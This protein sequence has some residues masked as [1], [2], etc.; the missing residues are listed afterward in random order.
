VKTFFRFWYDFI[1]GDDWVVAVGV[2]VVLGIAALLAGAGDLAWV[3][4]ALGMT[5]LL[6]LSVWRAARAHDGH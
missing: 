5:V 1:V 4:S 6:V 3:A 2:I